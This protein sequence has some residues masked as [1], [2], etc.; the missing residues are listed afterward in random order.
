MATRTAV[1][2]DHGIPSRKCFHAEALAAGAFGGLFGAPLK[3]TL[4]IS[5]VFSGT[6][7]AS[8]LRGSGRRLKPR[9]ALLH[10]HIH[11]KKPGIL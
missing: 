1:V 5:R 4:D 6:V 11:N 3:S 2:V 10:N 8:E 9:S 7:V